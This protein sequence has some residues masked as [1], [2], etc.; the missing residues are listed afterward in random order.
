MTT[1]DAIVYIVDDEIDVRKPLSLSIENK[2]YTVQSYGSALDFLNNYSAGSPGCLVLDNKLPG[3]SGVELQDELIRRNVLLPIIFISGY[4]DISTSVR[5]MKN[6]AIDFIE[7]PYRV[8]VLIGR[9]EEAIQ[10]YHE[11]HSK[12]SFEIAIRERFISLS[13]REQAIMRLMVAGVSNTSSRVIAD[14]LFISPRTVESHRANIM[15]KMQARSISELTEMAKI[16]AV[17]SA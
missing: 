4:S 3:M 14:T 6:G 2:G 9:I 8:S 5:A 16:C 17:Y 1:S 7:K 15:Q 11:M 13:S 12:R 10:N